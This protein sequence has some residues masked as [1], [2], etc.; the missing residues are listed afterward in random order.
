LRGLLNPTDMPSDEEAESG[1]S[2]VRPSISGGE[3]VEK[4]LG[5]KALGVDGVHPEFLKAVDV[6]GLSWLTCHCNIVRT[7]GPVPQFL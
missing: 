7:L 2:D 5:G 3:V 4:L 1:S 6:L